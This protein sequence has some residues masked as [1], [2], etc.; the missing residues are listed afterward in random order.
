MAVSPNT[1]GVVVNFYAFGQNGTAQAPSN[2]GR[3][4]VH[5][6]GHWLNLIHTWG[7]AY[8][9]ND[10]VADTPPQT[11]PH[12]NCN[13]TFPDL[14][15]A[16]NTSTEPYGTMFMDYMD[17]SDDPCLWMFTN[18]QSARMLS[19]FYTYRSS[20]L[21]A[22]VCTPNLSMGIIPLSQPHQPA[23]YPNPASGS[24][25]ISASEPIKQIQLFNVLG[26]LV[27]QDNFEN[28]QSSI[29]S[30]NTYNQKNG[31]YMLRVNTFSATTA[32]K[33]IIQH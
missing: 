24:L 7:D 30:I 22:N 21:N 10:S 16:C 2:L 20:I 31:V 3:T 28:I 33:V 14:T 6:V 17:Y 23:V 8:C 5:E 9:G 26:Q 27:F 13:V 25:T 1:D 32:T 29:Q 12:Y 19:A 4:C 18:D 11:Q 15:T